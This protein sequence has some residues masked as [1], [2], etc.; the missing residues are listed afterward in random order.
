MGKVIN[1]TLAEKISERMD[2]ILKESGLTLIGLAVLSK[3]G[4]SA[5]SSYHSKSIPIS[6]ETV[7]K[8]CEPLF[9]KLK[10]FFDFETNLI[11]STKALLVIENFKSLNVV[12]LPIYFKSTGCSKPVGS[13]IKWEREMIKYIVL[14]TDYFTTARSIAEMTL[15]FSK[16]Y[17]LTLKS[18]RLYNLLKKYI[19]NELKKEPVLRINNDSSK[20]KRTIFLYS[21]A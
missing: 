14:R 8:I 11:L 1:Y 17:G 4:K 20:S 10:D 5:I 13:G 6:V 15:D 7:N 16:D 18:G 19:G 2:T 21:R 9:I 3:V 12:N